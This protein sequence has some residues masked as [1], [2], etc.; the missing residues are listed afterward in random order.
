MER[1]R[2]LNEVDYPN[3]AEKASGECRVTAPR[4]P[5]PLAFTAGTSGFL[6]LSQSVGSL[7]GFN[8]KEFKNIL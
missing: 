8:E 7:S 2:V 5:P 6:N 4:P 3:R 1:L